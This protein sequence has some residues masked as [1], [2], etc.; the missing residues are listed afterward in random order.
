VAGALQIL[1]DDAA[2][3]V[4]T[5]LAV[6]VRRRYLAA[7]RWPRD[8]EFGFLADAIAALE[9][10]IERVEEGEPEDHDLIRQSAAAL[11]DLDRVLGSGTAVVPG[12]ADQADAVQRV[13]PA[14][15]PAPAAGD[16]VE[17][18]SD[19][20]A[21]PTQTGGISPEFLDI[22]LEEAQEETQA[23]GAQFARWQDNLADEGVLSALRRSF[24][25]L[26]GSGRLVGAVR[27]ADL[28]Q[29]AEGLLNGLLEQGLVPD[30]ARVAWLAAVVEVL[31][32]LV[33]AEAQQR[34]LDIAGLVS[35]AAQLGQSSG[36]A[37]AAL[38]S[39]DLQSAD[40]AARA[41]PGSSASPETVRRAG[42]QGTVPGSATDVTAAAQWPS[43]GL[44]VE[45]ADQWFAAQLDWLNAPPEAAPVVAAA[46]TPEEPRADALTAA[47]LTDHASVFVADDELLA[48]FRA[49]TLHHL[50]AVRAF[51]VRAAA[52]DAVPDEGTVR[53]LHTL[54][55][56]ARMSGIDSIANV[57][58]LLERRLGALQVAAEAATAVTLALIERAVDGI[59][60][61]I[62]ELPAIDTGADLL[63]A[64]AADL[65]AITVPEGVRAVTSE[66]PA[67]QGPPLELDLEG[68]ALP[69]L[70]LADASVVP[71]HDARSDPVEAVSV[72]LDQG[73][74]EPRFID[75]E[76]SD[77]QSVSDPAV[78]GG[79]DGDEAAQRDW[80]L[81]DFLDL[82][83]EFALA[84]DGG[85]DRSG[86][87]GVVRSVD[88]LPKPTPVHVPH[89]QDSGRLAA[90]DLAAELAAAVGV[91]DAELGAVTLPPAGEAAEGPESAPISQ[92]VIQPVSQPVGQEPAGP[93]CEP[94]GASDD[95]ADQELLSLFLDDGRDLLDGIDATLRSWQLAPQD[96][97][98]LDGINRLLH[99]LKGSA[100]LAGLSPIG[101]LSH[102]LETRLTAVRAARGQ[103]DDTTLEL[104]QR[105]VDTLSLQMDALQQ[106]TPL[107]RAAALVAALSQE[108]EPVGATDETALVI[109]RSAVSVSAAT[110]APPAVATAADPVSAPVGG[111]RDVG[112]GDGAAGSG[113][114]RPHQPA[115]RCGRRDRSLPRAPHPTQ[116][117][118]E[119]RSRGTRP[120]RAAIARSTASTGD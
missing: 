76:Q 67:V 72:L 3:Q 105:T 95:H 19:A 58:R 34:P 117:F 39:A 90:D 29:A 68:F 2:A 118:A 61:R 14:P 8:L 92:P 75:P 99:T 20:S 96:L 54:S 114:L 9:L 74:L 13:A 82:S 85:G 42:E 40:T 111:P 81:V 46:V 70:S 98:V 101:D 6:L 18:A 4:A 73:L 15:A 94:A 91:L 60:Q 109:L 55:G 97:G 22:F 71:D 112:G 50:D 103:V 93:S 33:A 107:P 49:E 7:D 38:T 10:H 56:S 53:A 62:A 80:D 12:D 113:A 102:A 17:A 16:A 110:P 43:A 26:K 48:I 37:A 86:P 24:H 30:A 115:G 52:G 106:H 78:P 47:D 41:W 59:A 116:R 64:L 83:D 63:L 35:R 69:P 120:D 104:A 119:F 51:L 77:A 31:P 11:R 108:P 84:E 23:I 88:E 89:P 65:T 57:A 44:L 25:T 27:I 87:S 21:R 28:A 36:T 66:A 100:R 5:D 32:N 45:S 79:V 1:G